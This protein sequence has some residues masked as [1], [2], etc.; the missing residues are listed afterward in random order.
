MKLKGE[1]LVREVAGELL[2]IP[3]GQTALDF[4]GMITLNEVGGE[5]WKLLPLVADEEELIAR[6]LEEYDVEESVL[7]QDV[8][9]FLGEL[10]ALKII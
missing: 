7:R 1:F 9:A 3:V 4:N 2:A 5:V 6:L 10:R 8:E